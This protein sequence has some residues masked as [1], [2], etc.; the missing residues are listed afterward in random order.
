MVTLAK[1]FKNIQMKKLIFFLIIS[2]VALQFCKTT[3]KATG[4]HIPVTYTA[5]IQPIIISNCSPCHIPPKGNKAALNTYDAAKM[6]ID[7]IYRRITM[8]PADKGFMPFKH[9]KL[10]DSLIHVFA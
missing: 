1:Y 7:D 8:D 9:P 5:D 4:S 6:H 2:L 10:S 3:K